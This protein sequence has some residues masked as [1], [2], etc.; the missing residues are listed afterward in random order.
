LGLP[1][2]GVKET[3][4]TKDKARKKRLKEGHHFN[5]SGPGVL[6]KSA[7][8]PLS[9]VH[10]MIY[11]PEILDQV[12]A[13]VDI[14]DVIDSVVP[15][16]KTGASW[17]ACC[18][19]HKEKTPSFNVSS[20]K[21]RFKCFGCGVGGDVFKF[22]QLYENVE[23][24]EAVRKVAGRAGIALPERNAPGD[25]ARR[26]VRRSL[27]GLHA[28]VA[29][30]WRELLLHDPRAEVARRYMQEREIP[31]TWARE[32]GL[33][34]APEAWDD[35]L[36]WAQAQKYPETLL[37]ESGLV[38]RNDQGRVYD[39]FRGRLVF[40]ISNENGEVIAFSARILDPE[41]K[42]AKYVNSP[43]T[44]VFTKSKVL[45]GYNRAK[46]PILEADRVV[47]CEGQIDVLRCHAAGITHV[48]APLGTAF[49]ED[50]ARILR[51][52]TRNVILCLDA[53]KAGQAA[54]ERVAQILLGGGGG[55][56]RLV[57]SDL[58]IQVVRLPAGHDPDSFIREKG[59]DAFRQLLDHPTDYLDFLIEFQ[60]QRHAADPGGRRKVVEAIAS[61]L[62]QIPN[63]AYREQLLQQAS[64][65]LQAAPSV[66]VEEMDRLRKPVRNPSA[67]SFAPERGRDRPDAE[68]SRAA[69]APASCDVEVRELI[70]LMLARPEMV[71]DL[72]R[73]I[74]MDWLRDRPGSGLLEKIVEMA[75]DGVLDGIESLA[76][77]VE[78]GEW[79][80]AESLP[81]D[82]VQSQ[83]ASDL[84]R[85][86]AD[87]SR[88]IHIRWVREQQLVLSRQLA[89]PA[90]SSE[91]KVALF[92]RQMELK[93]SLTS[94]V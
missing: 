34:F 67:A 79:A 90:L 45:F 38:V 5:V 25:D 78:D 80:L 74:H 94:P 35:T 36:K 87:L 31:L 68:A 22:V 84:L 10:S 4:G 30:Y 57:Q 12:R 66:L 6:G 89:D 18:P 48:V 61:F 52:T 70:T 58:G 72:L 41:A 37:L 63:A 46:R 15:L 82:L 11:G 33:G 49:T 64:T 1:R 62:A 92:Q 83:S 60:Q 29:A 26:D 19:F 13:A 32:F 2:G 76:G 14:V 23:F 8:A 85:A 86:L 43:E 28:E 27:L 40:P 77:R 65:R 3:E 53:D 16:K 69:V 73:G 88:K 93:K 54:A 44:P 24:P 51:R 47:I 20:E 50:H 7:P 39:R 42:A 75:N 9:Y 56:E 21:Q 71:A 17:K 91:E 55:L 81:F 59:G